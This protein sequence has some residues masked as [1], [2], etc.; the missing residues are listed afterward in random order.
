MA[1][2]HISI[3]LNLLQQKIPEDRRGQ[4]VQESEMSD[5]LALLGV[6]RCALVDRQSFLRL[7]LRKR[8]PQPLKI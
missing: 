5:Q 1:E 2:S 8:L 4:L 6:H 7:A 3:I